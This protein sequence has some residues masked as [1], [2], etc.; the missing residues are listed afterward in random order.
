MSQET[1]AKLQRFKELKQGWHYGEGKPVNPACLQK[2]ITLNQI[3]GPTV[4]TNAFPGIWGEVVLAIYVQNHYLEFTFESDGTTTFCHEEDDKEVCYRESL[5][6][7]QSAIEGIDVPLPRLPL[8]SELISVA[9]IIS[10]E[11]KPRFK[12]EELV[13]ELQ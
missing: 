12:V 2:A 9:V 6:D 1:E 3:L 11:G 13:E 5:S 8:E 7:W 10:D 4:K